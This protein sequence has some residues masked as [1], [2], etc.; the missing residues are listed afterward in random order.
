MGLRDWSPVVAVCASGVYCGGADRV[1]EIRTA[2]RISGCAETRN[3]KYMGFDH[4]RQLSSGPRAERQQPG[5][6]FYSN[7]L[8]FDELY[9]RAERGFEYLGRHGDRDGGSG[10]GGVE[11]AGVDRPCRAVETGLWTDA[12]ACAVCLLVH[13]RL[14]LKTAGVWCAHRFDIIIHIFC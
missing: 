5:Q 4:G 3:G 14:V 6:E 1:R 7:V 13:R 2:S 12:L 9:G 10:G 11:Y 8:G